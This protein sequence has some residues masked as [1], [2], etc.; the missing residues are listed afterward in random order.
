[1]NEADFD[2]EFDLDGLTRAVDLATIVE[3]QKA[4]ANKN[5]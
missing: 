5:A 2:K 3:H 4:H 1:M